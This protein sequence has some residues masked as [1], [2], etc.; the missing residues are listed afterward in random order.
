[1]CV[2][3]IASQRFEVFCLTHRSCIGH[4]ETFVYMHLYIVSW[5]MYVLAGIYL[6]GF[7]PG[8]FGV[9]HG[10][11]Q[12]MAYEELKKL[13]NKYHNELLNKKL[14]SVVCCRKVDIT[15]TRC[16]PTINFDIVLWLFV[17][18]CSLPHL[19]RLHS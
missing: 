4:F 12:F 3:V 11:L 19:I 13:C 1:M 7:L 16:F 2:K 18:L 8:I 9:S 5:E 10:A 17:E 14:V 6:Q 15:C